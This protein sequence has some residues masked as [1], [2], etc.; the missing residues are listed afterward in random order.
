MKWAALLFLM[1]APFWESKAPS[2]WTDDQL[3]QLLTD[4]PWAQMVAAPGD[5]VPAP[6]VQVFLSTAAPMQLADHERQIRYQ[7]KHPQE[8]SELADEYRVWLEDNR[9]TQIV[10]A[11]RIENNHGFFDE[12]ET[13][14]MEEES[15]MRIGRKK[16]KMTGHFPPSPGDPYVRMAF[17]R[18]VEPSDKTVNFELY[19]PGI[20]PPYRMAEF[21][22]KDMIVKGKLEM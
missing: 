17:P 19:L 6:P 7:R 14:R 22:V 21:K 16:I 15:V 20:T 3:L 13:R 5:S 12:K 10:V 8:K 4:S 18:Q 1:A 9:L 11:V 2:D